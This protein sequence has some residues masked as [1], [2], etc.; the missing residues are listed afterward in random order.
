MSKKESPQDVIEAYRKQQAR[1]QRAPKFMLF[2]SVVIIIAIAAF[3]IFGIIGKGMPSFSMPSIAALNPFV[4]KTPTPTETVTP[5]PTATSTET[6]PATET[7]IPT[8]TPTITLTPTRSGPSIYTVEEGDTFVSIAQKFEIEWPVLVEVNRERLDLDPANPI[9]RIGDELLIP[10]PGTEL[11]TSTP[12]PEGLP[13]GTKIEYSV[14]IGDSLAFIAE[15]FNST[16]ESIVQ[17]NDLE[18]ETAVIYAGQILIVRV[19]LVTPVPTSTVAPEA[20][21]TP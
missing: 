17:E 7:P 12:L 19:N 21:A 15:K 2:L 14:Q 3:I 20:T 5:S 10:P 13:R 9:I 11:P 8:D 1:S 4:S 16:V 18:D 6:P